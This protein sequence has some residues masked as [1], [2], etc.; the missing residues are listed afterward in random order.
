METKNVTPNSVT[1]VF[2]EDIEFIGTPNE[3]DFYHTNSSNS[4]NEITPDDI[5]GNELTL[6]WEDDYALPNGTAY[7]Y[8]AGETIQ[9]LWDNENAQQLR[10][11]V[12]VTEDTE[13]P[14]I[15]EVEAEDQ[16][17]LLVT[18]N[19]MLD[20]DSAEE[21]D[22]YVLLDEDGD[23]VDIVDSATRQGDD[24]NEV[25]LVL[26]EDIYGEYTL[27]VDGVEDRAG[28]AVSDVSTTFTVNDETAPNFD[29][30]DVYLYNNQD[31]DNGDDG[32]ETLIVEFNDTMAVD[33]DYSVVD[34]SKYKIGTESLE[35]D[36]VGISAFDQN[37]KVRIDI[38]VEEAEL[39]VDPS[40]DSLEIARVEDAAGHKTPN[41]SDTIEIEER[42]SFGADSITA[43]KTDEIEVVLEDK[44]TDIEQDDFVLGGSAVGNIT[45][46]DMNVDNSGSTTVVTLKL[47][48][49]L[50][51]NVNSTEGEITL[52]TANED[53]DATNSLGATLLIETTDVSD[54]ITPVLAQTTED[55]DN[56]QAH[57]TTD[58]EY[59]TDARIELT[60]SEPISDSSVSTA[61]FEVE[62]YTVSEASADDSGVVT[63]NL[64]VDADDE[65]E[66]TDLADVD[67]EQ[68]AYITDSVGNKVVDISTET[69]EEVND[70]TSE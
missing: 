48:G 16:S 12:E 41:F 25:E 63:L 70:E 27:V 51:Y 47:D 24:D 35:R 43:T 65:V 14:V 66:V 53:V 5:N 33:G 55:V 20:E 52:E 62:G 40:S 8:V 37:T 7:I 34:L 44:V 32:V 39:D 21:E 49:D 58:G 18:F 19:E 50:D 56:V 9:D 67:V 61:S 4:V 57:V 22:N 38:D 6:T 42:N 29:N 3:D 45:I 68:S 69:L 59:V 2:D 46:D 26:D 13:A 23:E 28:N 64:D 17:T 11:Q 60:F 15:E 54:G 30:F 31:V 10:V 36:G 1:L